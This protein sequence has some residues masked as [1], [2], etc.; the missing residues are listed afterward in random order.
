MWHE[1]GPSRQNLVL[2]LLALLVSL[3]VGAGIPLLQSN[4]ITRQEQVTWNPPSP[5]PNDTSTEPLGVAPVAPDADTLDGALIAW[6]EPGPAT[7]SSIGLA[8]ST[9]GPASSPLADAPLPTWTASVGPTETGSLAV[10]ASTMHR[11]IDTGTPTATATTRPTDTTT[12]E[13]TTTSTPQPTDT[14]T[15]GLAPTATAW[16]S[17]TSTSSNSPASTPGSS[18]ALPTRRPSIQAPVAGLTTATTPAREPAADR[19]VA[20]PPASKRPSS[21]SGAGAAVA[22]PTTP[23][24]NL[25]Q[26]PIATPPAL[27]SPGL[28]ARLRGVVQFDWHP[29]SVLPV[30]AYYEMV[31]W[32]PE[33]DPNQAWGVAP[34]RITTSLA[35]NLDELFQSGRFR[36]GSLYWTVLLVEQNPYRRLTQPTDS[37]RRYLVLATGG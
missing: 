32:S 13:A 31:V 2:S 3:A 14:L 22:K 33:Q 24:A 35:L 6:Q 1:I 29:S 17:A 5:T 34:P 21:G 8:M 16:L 26:P 37:E 18:L 9:A 12:P 4:S 10:T 36:E 23:T 25:A 7:P 27:L 28:E 19:V 30:G 15:P 20:S 11:P